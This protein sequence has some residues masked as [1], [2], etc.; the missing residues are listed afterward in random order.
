[1]SS[2]QNETRNAIGKSN[3]QNKVEV[4]CFK[5]SLIPLN[6]SELGKWRSAAKQ[7]TKETDRFSFL[8]PNPSPLPSSLSPSSFPFLNIYKAVLQANTDCPQV[9]TGTC[10]LIDGDHIESCLTAFLTEV[11][12]QDV[13]GKHCTHTQLHSAADWND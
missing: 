3:R 6:R 7:P 13:K 2:T 4:R 5:A 8:S 9:S 11:E 12:M 1:M 10:R